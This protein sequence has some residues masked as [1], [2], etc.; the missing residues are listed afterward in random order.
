MKRKKLFRI[1]DEIL[2]ELVTGAA[3]IQLP[4]DATLD[5][6]W[7]DLEHQGIVLKVRSETFPPV[8]EAQQI[9]VGELIVERWTALPS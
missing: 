4:K 3:R 9:T 8:M 6:V 7:L 5:G 1:P 2:L